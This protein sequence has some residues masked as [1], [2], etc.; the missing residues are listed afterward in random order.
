MN[1]VF[2][3]NLKRLRLAKKLTQEQT[4]ERLGVSAQSVSRW[5]CGNTYPDVMLLPEIARLYGVTVDD[6]YREKSVAYP[7][8]AQRLG[9]VYEATR[10]PADFIRAAE[11]FERLIASGDFTSDDMRFYG[12]IHQYMMKYCMKK[13]EKVFGDIIDGKYP[14][15]EETVWRTKHQLQGFLAQ[16]GR[17]QV[18]VERQRKIVE[19]GS[20]NVRDWVLLMNAY[21]FIDE[22]QKALE[23]FLKGKDQFP[24]DAL[25]MCT[26][27]DI[28]CKLRQYKEAFACWDRA[29]QLDPSMYDVRYSVGFCYE[30]MGE[31]AKACNIWMEIAKDLERDGFEMELEFP[32]KLARKCKEKM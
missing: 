18:S 27:G 4:A 31:Y 6:L 2:A 21:V 9:A 5:E 26:G 20:R 12:I 17:G 32:R 14:G 11:A 13:S 24:D 19:N 7:N 30:E 8:Y 15:D 1:Q 22:S 28:Y 10:D 25:L 23:W 29:L 3:D 16:I